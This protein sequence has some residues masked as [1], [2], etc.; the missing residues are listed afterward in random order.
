MINRARRLLAL[1]AA[2]PGA[3][4]AAAASQPFTIAHPET[5]AAPVVIAAAASPLT[6]TNAEELA[7][8]IEQM[9][10][11]LAAVAAEAPAGPAILVGTAAEFPD[12]PRLRELQGR[13][14]EAF[15]PAQ[16]GRPPPRRRQQRPGRSGWDLHAAAGVGLPLVLPARGLDGDPRAGNGADR[17][18]PDRE[19]GLRLPAHLVRLGG[20]HRKARRGL[21]RLEPAQPDARVVRHRLQ[22]RLGPVRP[23]QP[24][25]G[26]PGILRAQG[27][28][29]AGAS[30]L[31]DPS[32]R[33]PAG[34]RARDRDLRGGAGSQ[35]G[36]LRSERQR[37]VLRRGTAA[38]RSAPS[39]TASFCSRTR[40]PKGLP[41]ASRA[42][43]W[44]C[45]PTPG[46]PTRPPS[47][48][49]RTS[50]CS[51]PGGCAGRR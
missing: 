3:L 29:A 49:T 28:R 38:W 14:P 13:S 17:G 27:R 24:P 39:A 8:I 42:S 10:G 26:A 43:T 47:R 21:F 41:P 22:P 9:S 20:A 30:A 7:R 15:V 4:S 35:H 19:P 33:D 37:R 25:R 18:R 5:G 11:H 40:S 46:T 16:H 34:D 1:G 44:D 6:R 23:R 48:C 2:L 12:T 45:C 32:G 36:A 51:S 50:T 31:H